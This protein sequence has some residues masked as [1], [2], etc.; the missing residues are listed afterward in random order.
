MV[1]GSGVFCGSLG[2]IITS[3][4]KIEI[5]M[6]KQIDLP[7]PRP[8]PQPPTDDRTSSFVPPPSSR[9]GRGGRIPFATPRNPYSQGA[10]RWAVEPPPSTGD[11][12]PTVDH[13]RRRLHALPSPG[14]V[15]TPSPTD[16]TPVG[17]PPPSEDNC[18]N[19]D[20]VSSDDDLDEEPLLT[21]PPESAPIPL[22]PTTI[23]RDF[24]RDNAAYAPPL[25]SKYP[26][27]PREAVEAI[28]KMFR[29]VWGIDPRPYQ[30]SAVFYIVYLKLSMTYLIRKTGEGKSMVW[31]GMC[32]ILRGVNVCMVPLL[33]LGSAQAATSRRHQDNI[34]AIRVKSMVWY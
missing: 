12:T 29:D 27:P 10:I 2:I 6:P 5:A 1:W 15:S 8:T 23:R 14:A 26:T 13:L 24:D 30:V 28:T 18:N 3:I 17:L 21:Q 34:E 33:G 25:E 22:P 20:D 7:R 16:T 4:E 32:T 11:Q 9:R 31:L 19:R